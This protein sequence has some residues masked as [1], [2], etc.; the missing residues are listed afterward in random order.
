M[1]AIRLLRRA[2]LVN[3]PDLRRR[4]LA[5]SVGVVA[6]LGF[7]AA[8]VVSP[9]DAQEPEIRFESSRAWDHLEALVAFGPRPSGSEAIE[10]T[11][12]YLERTLLELQLA[13]RREAF[14]APTPEG[15]IAFAN[16]YA[17]LRANDAT[18]ATRPMV[19]LATHFDTK[20]L[21]FEFVGAN[22]GGSGTAVLLELAHVLTRAPKRRVDYRF[23]FLDGE[24]ALRSF[25]AGEDN[26]YGS[27]HHVAELARTK[28]LD[29]VRA[30]V[31]IDMVGD[32]DLRLTREGYSNGTL[33]G[34]FFDAAERIGLGSHVGARERDVKDDHRRFLDAGVPAVDLIDFEYGPY[35]EH[36][37]AAGDTLAN[38][39]R[40]SLD[41]IGRIVLAGIGELENFALR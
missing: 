28:A 16:I 10:R 35:N 1:R 23:L 27:R 15:E 13:P 5:S 11:R 21:A 39:S 14:R 22:D 36:W 34:I 29:R 18:D 24:E 30:F 38:C 3:F 12:L 31:L 8:C 9:V 6:A 26:C 20:R 41:A 4:W 17:D 40:A 32:A 2:S 19:I 25:W 33:L 37:H 7:V